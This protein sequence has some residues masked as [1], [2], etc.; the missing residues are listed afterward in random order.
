MRLLS[1]KTKM[2]KTTM[3]R[4]VLVALLTCF[5]IASGQAEERK[6]IHRTDGSITFVVDEGL[7]PKEER[8]RNLYDGERIAKDIV[9]EDRNII[10]D[11]CLN[12][13]ATSFSE[14]ENLRGDE[15]DAFFQCV[16]KAYSWHK[17][18]TLS[19]DMIWLLISQG[20]A[21]Y[22]KA[23][24]EAL[25]PL[26]VSHSGKMDL[27]VET[28]RDLLSGEADSE[29]LVGDFASEIAKYTSDSIASVLTS[30]FSTTLPAER[31]VSQITLMESVK[32]YFIY[33]SYS[34]ACGIPS[35]TLKGTPADWRRVLDKT[36]R[37]AR[38]GLSDWT[39]S[40][41]PI[42]EQFVLASEGKPNQ[43]FWQSIVKKTPVDRLRG[44]GC[45]SDLP[46]K[47]DGW[48]LKFFPDKAG[49]TPDKAFHTSR[50]P[51]E[52]V[53][54]GFTHRVL[55]TT[56][57]SVVSEQPMEFIAGF[58]GAQE[59]TTANMLTPK[60]GWLLRRAETD[61]ERLARLQ[62]KSGR[63]L[64]IRVEELPELLRRV[65]HFASLRV[66]FTGD[67]ILPEWFPELRYTQFHIDGKVKENEVMPSVLGKLDHISH[68]RLSYT[69]I[70]GNCYLYA[71]C[72]GTPSTPLPKESDGKR[73]I[74]S[75]TLYFADK[76]V[77]PEW[78]ESCD[79]D[80]LTVEAKLKRAEKRKLTKQL[81]SAGIGKFRFIKE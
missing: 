78:L 40:L 27:A 3:C 23:H 43:K 66:S 38:Y 24:S 73:H 9:H 51:S 70:P 28:N 69:P 77:L 54:V 11:S 41:E 36:R 19:P 4:E 16:L 30:D 8:F 65:D 21:R 34:A 63:D 62:E 18:I 31:I 67:I 59:D 25:R 33:T 2:Q 12:I 45:S 52:R 10:D 39:D 81:Q 32:S 17:S 48:L 14:A 50:M 22:V 68:L 29:K 58:I 64:H 72:E 71:T 80:E 57:G 26:L 76:V 7:E 74:K 56:D 61:D 35:I 42:L 15:K 60:I 13:V 79:I 47:I 37:L 1:K 20:F 75:L 46:T 6:V 44:G 55:S 49:I 5:A 53:C